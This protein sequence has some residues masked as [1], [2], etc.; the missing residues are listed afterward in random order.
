VIIL[1]SLDKIMEKL[2]NIIVEIYKGRHSLMGQII[3]TKSNIIR[4]FKYENFLFKKIACNLSHFAQLG[5]AST[6]GSWL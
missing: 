2:L 3:I 5:A 6:S 1:F 4:R